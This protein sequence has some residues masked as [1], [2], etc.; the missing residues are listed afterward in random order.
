MLSV[1]VMN[2]TRPRGVLFLSDG[3][4]DQCNDCADGCSGNEDDELAI[5]HVRLQ[6]N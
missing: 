2:L 4:N 3:L 1:C 6:V 5:G